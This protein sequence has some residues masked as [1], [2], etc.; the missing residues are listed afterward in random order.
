M[1]WEVNGELHVVQGSIERAKDIIQSNELTMKLAEDTKASS[2]YTFFHEKYGALGS[3]K[4]STLPQNKTEVYGYPPQAPNNKWLVEY[5]PRNILLSQL[6]EPLTK[7]IHLYAWQ[8]QEGIFDLKSGDLWKIA[9]SEK[10]I[11]WG[12]ERFGLEELELQK[13]AQA[14]FEKWQTFIRTQQVR[15]FE[16]ITDVILIQIRLDGFSLLVFDGQTREGKFL[17]STVPQSVTENL[18]KEP[19]VPDEGKQA[20]SG[21]AE[22]QDEKKCIPIDTKARE[23]K[24]REVI[25]L[26]IPESRKAEKVGVGIRQYQRD[27][28]LLGLAKPRKKAT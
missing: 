1:R 21:K 19:P 5:L 3:V 8:I 16:Q 27:K 20:D 14:E 12:W 2:L 15:E 7:L 22:T 25:D 26:D 18:A 17:K 11:D 9:Y 23:Q 10:K 13:Q 4:I 28:L 24:I 6:G